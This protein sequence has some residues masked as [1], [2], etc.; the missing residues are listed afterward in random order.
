M[1]IFFIAFKVESP[2]SYEGWHDF[3]SH[4]VINIGVG[5][6]FVALLI[7]AWVGVRDVIV[8]YIHPWVLRFSLLVLLG[9]FLLGMG[10][11]I[12]HILHI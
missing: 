6:F 7:H 10:L 2:S 12:L 4:P 9:M 3:M 5:L 8:D 11:W 1:L